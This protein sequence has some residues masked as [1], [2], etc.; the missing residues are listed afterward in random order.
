MSPVLFK[1]SDDDL[2]TNEEIE[3]LSETVS[4]CE[5]ETDDLDYIPETESS[6]EEELP[7]KN[8]SIIYNGCY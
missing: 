5:S 4:D 6:S 8:L 7:K 3:L 1:V 2:D